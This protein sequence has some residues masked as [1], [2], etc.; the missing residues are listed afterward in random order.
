MLA[1]MARDLASHAM[2]GRRSSGVGAGD[3][4]DALVN[5]TLAKVESANAL[6]LGSLGG[7]D[8][9]A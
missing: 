6:K 5:L 2:G 1:G 9:D 7:R 8:G 4:E 3:E